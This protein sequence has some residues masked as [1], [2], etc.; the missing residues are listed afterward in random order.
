LTD[1]GAKFNLI[2]LCV[3][4]AQWLINQQ[5]RRMIKHKTQTQLQVPHYLARTD[6]RLFALL[7]MRK[8]PPS[9]VSICSGGPHASDGWVALLDLARVKMLC[10]IYYLI[11]SHVNSARGN[12]WSH[13]LAPGATR[14]SLQQCSA[15]WKNFPNNLVR[16]CEKISLNSFGHWKKQP[17]VENFLLLPVI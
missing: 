8:S 4:T 6:D 10:K 2:F 17:F 13:S 11:V 15:K 7:I 14:N 3:R 12:R 1:L 9:L 5:T 16:V